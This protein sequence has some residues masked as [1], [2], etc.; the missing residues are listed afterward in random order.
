MAPFLARSTHDFL[1]NIIYSKLQGEVIASDDSIA[2]MVGCN[3]RSI[4]RIRS[5]LLAFGTIEIPTNTP[6]R[7]KSI[8]PPMLSALHSELGVDPCL[9]LDKLATFLYE[10]Y[11]T[12]VSRFTISRTLRED[13]WSQKA[14]QNVAQER[15]LDLRD[16]FM[17]QISQLRSDQL[18]FVDE[19]GV[20]K[21]I[22]TR[23]RGWAP[24]GKRPRQIKRFHRGRRYQILPAYTQ[25]GVI[26]FRVFE[27]STDAKV[28]ES[29]I[30]T[31]LLYCGRWPEPRS[32]LIMDNASFH[33][34]ERI[35]EMCS[36]AGV[37]LIYSA[38]YSPDI[39]PIEH[40][41]GELKNFTRKVW[42]EHQGF[43]RADFQ[44]FLEECVMVVGQRKKSARGHFRSCSISI[45]E[46]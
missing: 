45:D 19:S 29:F 3:P 35:Q 34:S 4:C 24:R 44:G 28:F 38:P 11:D 10:H 31:L 40:F 37:V 14:T 12:D 16:E 15:N 17:H 18:V 5:K 27:G 39:I 33:H 8:T 26:H 41:F 1:R 43:I 6:G 42:D 46:P 23:R 32:V 2:E 7:P 25:D 22:G 36:E 21:S 30:E 13:K 9:T 20:D